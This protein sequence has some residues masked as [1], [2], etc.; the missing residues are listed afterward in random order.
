MSNKGQLKQYLISA[1]NAYLLN[2]NN[3]GKTIMISGA[4]GSG[5]THFWNEIEVDLKKK[6]DESKKACLTVSLYGKDNLDDLKKEI[7][8][9]AS[10]V[11]KLL[12]KSISS[13]GFDVLSSI[14]DSDLKIGQALLTEKDQEEHFKWLRQ[15]ESQ[16]KALWKYGYRLYCVGDVGEK[17]YNEISKFIKTGILI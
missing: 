10:S 13:F 1:D 6:L 15:N 4:W 11:D 9:N 7:L 2:D 14:K 3:N 5:K 16:L 12:S 8:I 17:T